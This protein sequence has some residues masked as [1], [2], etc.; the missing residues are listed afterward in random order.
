MHAIKSVRKTGKL[1]PE[2]AREQKLNENSMFVEFFF[3]FV[4]LCA[5]SAMIPDRYARN[6]ECAQN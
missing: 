2:N 5:Q 6:K 1:V 4:F 3:F